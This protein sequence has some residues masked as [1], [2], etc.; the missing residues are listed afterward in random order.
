M[1]DYGTKKQRLESDSFRLFDAC[2]LCLSQTRDTVSCEENGDI[3]CK[4]CIMENLLTQRKEIKKME[5]EIEKKKRQDEIEEKRIEEIVK[6]RTIKEFEVLQMGFNTRYNDNKHDDD[7]VLQKKEVKDVF[8]LDKKELLMIAKNDRDREKLKY[9]KEHEIESK[10]KAGSFWIPS[11]T[12]SANNKD[13]LKKQKRVPICPA[14]NSGNPHKISLKSL[15]SV[16]FTEKKSTESKETLRI[17]PSCKKKLS[18]ISGAYIMKLCGHV[19]CTI[20]L[21]QFVRESG[22][23]YVCE[24]SLY[25]QNNGTM[26]NESKL[27][28]LQLSS[29]G[30]G[31]SAKKDAIA[32]K[33]DVAFQGS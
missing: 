6:M 15:I 4:V 29:E 3:F 17:C 26:K 25:V 18:N 14:S 8:K 9:I 33:V 31:F 1:L 10:P 12:P 22:V 23:C 30:T 5:E 28:I 7:D 32:K 21:D 27:L 19:I 13:I 16:N 20:C 2:H 24:S 11:S